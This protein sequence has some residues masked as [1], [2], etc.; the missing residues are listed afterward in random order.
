MV[1][2]WFF[3]V[4][5]VIIWGSFDTFLFKYFLPSWNTRY[6]P[7]AKRRVIE[8]WMKTFNEDMLL[9]VRG[10]VLKNF[11][12]YFLQIH[13]CVMFNEI[14]CSVVPTIFQ[15]KLEIINCNY[16][17][18]ISDL[19]KIIIL[20]WKLWFI[21]TNVYQTIIAQFIIAKPFT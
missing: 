19:C 14:Q 6:N 21:K 16:N 18:G 7:F 3:L 2:C 13:K 15:L 9:K 8:R 12:P 17:K 1:G 11:K 20:V 5:L 10:S 4:H